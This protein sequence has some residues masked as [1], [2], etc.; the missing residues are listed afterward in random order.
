MKYFLIIAL[1]ILI[2]CSDRVAG[3]HIKS[4]EKHYNLIIGAER[5]ASAAAHKVLKSTRHMSLDREVIRGGY[6]DY[7]DKAW[8]RAGYPYNKRHKIYSKSKHGPYAPTYILQPGDW[9]YHI[10]HS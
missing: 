4:Y 2:G 8:T 7:L 9:I 1:F 5:R 10:N 6:W 3:K